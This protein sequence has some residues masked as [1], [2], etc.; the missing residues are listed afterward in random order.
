MLVCTE[1]LAFVLE[2][3]YMCLGV[4]IGFC[5]RVC[6][7]SSVMGVCAHTYLYLYVVGVCVGGWICVRLCRCDT[8]TRVAVFE[9]VNIY[10]VLL[11]GVRSLC[12]W[13]VSVRVEYALMHIHVRYV[14]I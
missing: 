9:C 14:Y 5:V 4:G 8:G 7:L 1:L 3:A 6:V 12:S 13:N 11:C 10:C 2:F